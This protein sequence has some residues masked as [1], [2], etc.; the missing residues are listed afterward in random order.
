MPS[1]NIERGVVL[2][3]DVNVIVPFG[4]DTVG[5]RDVVVEGG[6]RYLEVPRVRKTERSER[7]KR[8]KS[9]VALI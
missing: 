6:P 2:L 8:G 1:Y 7:P 5:V 3:C 9:K 4:E